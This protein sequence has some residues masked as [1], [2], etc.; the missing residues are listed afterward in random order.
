[1]SPAVADRH[2]LGR[3]TVEVSALGFGAAAMGY[4]YEGVSDEDAR[5]TMEHV[6]ETLRYVDVAPFY[7]F[8]LAERRVGAV[9]R[10]RARD[11][12]VLST[13]V[14]RL[15]RPEAPDGRAGAALYDFSRDGILRSVEE[16]LTRL[17]LD[18]VDILYIHDPDDHV[19]QALSE[20]YPAVAELRDQG[21]VGAIGVGMN[22]SAVPTR[23]VTDTDI[24]C[25]LLAGRYTLL[26]QHS[27]ADLLPACVA[28]GVSIV[29]GGVYNSG[30][31]A[32]PRPDSYYNYEPVPEHLLRRAQALKGV[33]DR[34]D[35]PL[36][37]AAIQFPTHHPAIASVLTGARSIAEIDENVAM[38][39]RPV[40]AELWKDLVEAELI[41]AESVT[42]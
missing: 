34:H 36:K 24:D 13:K 7:G 40:P 2:R 30:V 9:L 16:S 3:S 27:L 17:G 11:S 41:P 4:L 21:V 23:F 10:S 35:V 14:G 42:S 19:E 39:E 15:L 38:F 33:C 5:R 1:M 37:A 8:G 28:N 31:L 26:E 29:I 18:R 25:V 20:A 22:Q 32:D 12:F 6:A